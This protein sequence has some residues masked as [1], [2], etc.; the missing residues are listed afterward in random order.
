M[1]SG[2]KRI[3]SLAKLTK[4][5]IFKEHKNI[6]GTNIKDAPFGNLTKFD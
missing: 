1:L 6:T 5:Y 4:I 2:L 3:S